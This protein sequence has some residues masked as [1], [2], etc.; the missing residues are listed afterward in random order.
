MRHREGGNEVVGLADV[1]SKIANLEGEHERFTAVFDLSNY[2]RK[3]NDLKWATHLIGSLQAYYPERLAAAV[4]CNASWVFS[5]LWK[6]I[7]PFL[8]KKTAD[9][10]V[11]IGRC[12]TSDVSALLWRRGDGRQV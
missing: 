11:F 6:I 2:S 8:D 12:E 10:I 1:F 9:K 3:N 7:K 5:L 4:L